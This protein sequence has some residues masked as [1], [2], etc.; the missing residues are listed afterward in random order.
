[1]LTSLNGHAQCQS[2]IA[3]V[4]T[5]FSII[6]MY[7]SPN[8]FPCQVCHQTRTWTMLSVIFRSFRVILYLSRTI[9]SHKF[10]SLLA[11]LP[12]YRRVYIPLT[13]L[14]PRSYRLYSVVFV[15]LG[16]TNIR[17]PGSKKFCEWKCRCDEEFSLWWKW[18]RSVKS[19]SWHHGRGGARELD[20]K[21][22]Y[23]LKYN[24]TKQAPYTNSYLWIYWAWILSPFFSS[25][26]RLDVLTHYKN[27]DN[28]WINSRGG[29]KYLITGSSLYT[30][31]SSGHEASTIRCLFP[32]RMHTY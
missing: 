6:R 29:W 13:S 27:P 9:L 25:V 31:L 10:V 16:S 19:N 18:T 3:E 14:L 7:P 24:T 15:L 2:V 28:M 20:K 8:S 12:G 26:G 22:A 1:M 17:S 23:C 5:H 11:A 30:L 32:F 4:S 21:G